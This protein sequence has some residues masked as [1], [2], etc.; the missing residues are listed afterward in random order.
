[1]I[2]GLG[3]CVCHPLLQGQTEKERPR[4]GVLENVSAFLCGGQVF[5]YTGR[6]H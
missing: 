3:R 5:I 2:S 4:G 6:E 1:M